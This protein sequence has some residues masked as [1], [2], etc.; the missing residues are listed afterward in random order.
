MIF[1]QRIILLVALALLQPVFAS[2][3]NA[4][5]QQHEAAADSHAHDDEQEEHDGHAD[6]ADQNSDEHGHAEDGAES[7]ADHTD[8]HE[9]VEDGQAGYD[10]EAD[11]VQLDAH[12]LQLAGIEV[13]ALQA[14]RVSYEFYAPGEIKANG[15]TSYIVSPRTDSVVLKR[16]VALGEHVEAGQALVTLFSEAV[17]D[18]QAAFQL[19]VAEWRR[20]NRLGRQAV[21]EKRFVEARTSYEGAQ[22][23]L[24]AFGMSRDAIETISAGSPDDLG[25][26]TLT[27]AIN[28]VVLSDDFRQGQRVEA[29]D[30]LMELADEDNLWVEARLSPG[31]QI[32]LVAGSEAHVKVGGELFAAVV[33]QEAHT[34]DSVTRTRIVRLVVSNAAHRLHPGMFADVYFEFATAS[35]VLVVPESALMRG[36]DGDWTVFVE[37]EPGEFRAVEVELGRSLGNVQEVTGIRSGTRVVTRGAFFV[38]SQ[39]AKGGFDPHNH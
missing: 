32:K 9:H 24:L 28:G 25:T 27:A 15:Y 18:A 34:I 26:Y 31:S 35:P 22:G 7:D 38:A 8:E 36:A 3:A 14:Q 19:S 5:E 23:R 16:H 2:S 21:G 29:G 1:P 37:I 13:T 6:A 12:Q 10:D 39:V 11:A 20:V 17:T 4:A 33:A 30:A